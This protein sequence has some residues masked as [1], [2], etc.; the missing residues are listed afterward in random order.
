[1]EKVKIRDYI[2]YVTGYAITALCAIAIVF[3]WV[4]YFFAKRIE[5]AIRSMY[6][7]TLK[8]LSIRIY[9]SIFFLTSG[10]SA[11][12]ASFVHSGENSYADEVYWR[13]SS[14][15]LGASGVC[16]SFLG[17]NLFAQDEL[18]GVIGKKRWVARFVV[19]FVVVLIYSISICW[20]IL[21]SQSLLPSLS[22]HLSFGLFGLGCLILFISSCIV[23][24]NTDLF[25]AR[26]PN[27]VF[28]GYV[29]C[30]VKMGAGLVLYATLERHCPF[31]KKDQHECPL[32]EVLSIHSL[33][34]STEII[35]FISLLIVVRFH[36]LHYIEAGPAIYFI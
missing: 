23:Y 2:N 20:N 16:L 8:S 1:M 26:A 21:E 13:I 12:C 28:L 14:G 19:R 33:L 17:V 11:A 31:G 36:L 15:A 34:H 9:P 29:A 18:A 25:I 7:C 3:L 5:I 10:I 4:A 22:Y 27:W 6:I 24:R 35:G 32:P 30:S